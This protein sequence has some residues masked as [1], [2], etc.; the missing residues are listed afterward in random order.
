MSK[1]YTLLLNSANSVNR[2][3]TSTSDYSYYINWHSLLPKSVNKFDV[4]FSL[5]S[6]MTTTQQTNIILLAINVGNQTCFDQNSSQ[7]Q[8]CCAI[9]PK[10]NTAT[11]PDVVYYNYESTVTDE[12]GFM[13]GFPEN[14]YLN[15]RVLNPTPTSGVYALTSNFQHYILQV[16][17]TEIDE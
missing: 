8:I 15:I 4:S 13:C 6:Q 14:D 9:T 11:Y 5:K 10:S 16:S 1:T 3:G 2:I 17:F 12:S 7:T